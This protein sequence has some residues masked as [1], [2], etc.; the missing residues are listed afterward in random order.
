MNATNHDPETDE[1]P[2]AEPAW[3]REAARARYRRLMRSW[4]M[5]LTYVLVALVILFS[6]AW[7]IAAALGPDVET[8]PGHDITLPCRRPRVLRATRK[9]RGYTP[10]R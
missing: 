10:R 9:N 5:R 4:P 2:P 1:S 7:G 3:D 8:L 6:W